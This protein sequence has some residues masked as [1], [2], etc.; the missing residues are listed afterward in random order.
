MRGV[1][2]LNRGSEK[3]LEQRPEGG[4]GAGCVEKGKRE[5][6]VQQP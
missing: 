6:P 5:Q 4:E 2:I 3:D 1:A